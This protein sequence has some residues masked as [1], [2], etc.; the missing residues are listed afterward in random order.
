MKVPKSALVWLFAVAFPLIAFSTQSFWI[1]EAATAKFVDQPNLRLFWE[2]MITGVTSDSQM[3]LYMLYAWSWQKIF[4]RSEVLLRLANYPWF[5]LAQVAGAFIWADRRKGLLFIS[6]AASSCFI[7]FYLDEAR[8]YIMQYAAACV[9]IWFLASLLRHNIV[10][11]WKYWLFVF[12]TTVLAGS[13]MLGVFWVGTSV[14]VATAIIVKKKVRPPLLPIAC[15]AAALFI[16]GIYYIWTLRT[17]ARATYSHQ[18][19]LNIPFINY[20]LLGFV[21]LGPGRLDIREHALSSFYPYLIPIA[22]FGLV[23]LLI[24]FRLWKTGVRGEDKDVLAACA[25]FELPP[26]FLLSIL[27]IFIEFSILGRHVMPAAPFIFMLLMLGLYDW[28]RHKA[29]SG[30]IVFASFFLLS[31]ASIFAIRFSPTHTKDDYRDAVAVVSAILPSHGVAWWCASKEGA[32]YY[33]LTLDAAPDR[34]GRRFLYIRNP[35]EE[36]LRKLPAPVVVVL[37]KRDL[38]DENGTIAAMLK[39]KAYV[40]RQTLPAFSIWEKPR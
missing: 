11:T 34:Q 1:D 30:R 27:G 8:P 9:L 39:K 28:L 2:K 20:E 12:S 26:V 33:H 23:V 14:L 32:E 37:S 36:K 15:G 6:I 16:L 10:P 31:I 21:G 18:T 13:S 3:P 4:G 5:L 19:I 40:L 17:G 35:D 29:F 24:F 7:W 38:Y 25:I 22:A